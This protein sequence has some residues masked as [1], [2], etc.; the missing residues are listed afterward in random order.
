M[1][2]AAM[3]RPIFWDSPREN[4]SLVRQGSGGVLENIKVTYSK[5]Y[6]TKTQKELPVGGRNNVRSGM[7]S[8]KWQD[9]QHSHFAAEVT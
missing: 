8:S 4:V 9:G 1:V 2:F 6:S 7:K 3:V 5:R